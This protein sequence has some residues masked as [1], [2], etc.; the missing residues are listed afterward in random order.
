MRRIHE[1]QRLQ[2]VRNLRLKLQRVLIAAAIFAVATA[3]AAE[4]RFRPMLEGKVLHGAEV[5]FFVGVDSPSIFRRSLT[6]HDVRCL[7]ADEAIEL[8]E[9]AWNFFARHPRG[10]VSVHPDFVAVPATEDSGA[11]SDPDAIFHNVRIEMVAAG[12][13]DFSPLRDTIEEGEF[14]AVY[15]P[16][17]GREQSTASIR[18]VPLGSWTVAVPAGTAVL[19]LIV[20]EGRITGAGQLTEVAHGETARAAN[21]SRS[22]IVAVTTNLDI[23]PPEVDALA[24]TRSA[25]HL[26]LTT[27][28]GQELKPLLPLRTG[29][30]FHRSVHIFANV[31]PGT[32]LVRLRGEHWQEDNASVVV[33]ASGAAT[34]LARPLITR[35]L[36]GITVNWSTAP[37]L[38]RPGGPRSCSQ[39]PPDDPAASSPAPLVKLLRCRQ[40][41]GNPVCHPVSEQELPA[42][43]SG[44]VNFTPLAAGTYR[45][46]LH[47]AGLLQRETIA[48]APLKTEAVQ[49][50]IQ[51]TTITGRVTRG[52]VPVRATILFATGTAVSD[53]SGRFEALLSGNPRSALVRVTACP[54]ERWTHTVLPTEPVLHGTALDIDIPLTELHVDVVDRTTNEPVRNARVTVDMVLPDGSGAVVDSDEARANEKGRVR[55]DR[56]AIGATLEVCASLSPTHP[57]R[58]V[59]RFVLPEDD[60]ARTIRVELSRERVLEGQ[61]ETTVALHRAVVAIVRGG[62]ILSTTTVA[63]DGK[64]SLPRA[65]DLGEGLVLVAGNH[66]L[67]LFRR[68]EL[69]PEA[70]PV[71]LRLPN[72]QPA[73]FLVALAP[74]ASPSGQVALMIG[75]V[76]IPQSLFRRHQ[77]SRG[78][79]DTVAADRPVTVADISAAEALTVMFAPSSLQHTP[80][81]GA[82][83]IF[84]SAAAA[85]LPRKVVHPGTRVL[86]E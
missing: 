70:R 3:A 65:D 26:S 74:N 32:H 13:L 64:F 82:G 76:L 17:H 48:L 50:Q 2:S 11:R 44:V 34:T 28:A 35:P 7:P 71:K 80:A 86:F 25:P 75:N 68:S 77:E 83:D 5:C 60:E 72:V 22:G 66:P 10:Y 9:G 38:V 15:F 54:D 1:T 57:Q 62:R 53:A 36:S 49:L 41:G 61:I 52:G 73:G 33:P 4:T 67:V 19:P 84:V 16:N 46:E 42:T 27:A 23:I 12:S 18:P 59:P 47:H 45:V 69:E 63:P 81:A 55:F 56:F 40:D 37:G 31:P 21:I 6:D 29:A 30:G 43:D 20:R 85:G 79:S 78:S 51:P 39:D 24:V 14:F 8:T 58:C